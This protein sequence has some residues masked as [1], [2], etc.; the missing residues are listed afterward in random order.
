MPE[1]LRSISPTLRHGIGKETLGSD[2]TS[3]NDEVVAS[4]PTPIAMTASTPTMNRVMG[5]RTVRTVVT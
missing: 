1:S 3:E 2:G 5:C 4:T